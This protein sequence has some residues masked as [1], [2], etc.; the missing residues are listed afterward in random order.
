MS[1]S[2]N[3]CSL[4]YKT[5]KRWVTSLRKM[6]QFRIDQIGKYITS[7]VA[8][9]KMGHFD[10]DHLENRSLRKWSVRKWVTSKRITS[11]KGHFKIDCSQNGSLGKW[12]VLNGSLQN[13][14]LR[15]CVT[16]KL[17]A[18]KIGH[19]ESDRFEVSEVIQF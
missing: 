8:T 6:C 13:E 15:K 19:F 2:W 12:P 18:H 10:I 4:T 7:K 11:E 5:L 9:L 14:S 1:V 16:S 3:I 17:I